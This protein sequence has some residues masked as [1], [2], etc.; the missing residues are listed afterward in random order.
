MDYVTL[1]ESKRYVADSLRLELEYNIKMML[2]NAWHA[3]IGI[4]KA[5]EAIIFRN[6]TRY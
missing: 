2:M 1:Q 5:S 4:E 6:E 3:G